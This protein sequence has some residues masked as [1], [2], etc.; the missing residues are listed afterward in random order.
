LRKRVVRYDLE[1]FFD[2]AVTNPEK[3]KKLSTEE[4]LTRL[5]DNELIRGASEMGLVSDLGFRHLD[6]IRYMRNWC[7]RSAPQSKPD[8]RTTAYR[9]VRDLRERGDHSS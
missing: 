5:E 1:Y 3:R 8:H 4:D 2:L 6:Y 7:Q 9:L